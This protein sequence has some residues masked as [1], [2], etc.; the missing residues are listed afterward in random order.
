ML[1]FLSL[2]GNKA[3]REF[4]CVDIRENSSLVAGTQR[5]R[6]AALNR[7]PSPKW[8]C[9]LD[10]AEFGS[11]CQCLQALPKVEVFGLFVEVLPER[12]QKAEMWNDYSAGR[13]ELSRSSP[14]RCRQVLIRE[15]LAEKCRRW[16]DVLRL[17]CPRRA[18]KPLKHFHTG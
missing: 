18:A 1:R 15:G 6:Q 2:E 12:W 4:R 11:R 3:R 14:E 16:G 9:W 17:P 5:Q 13:V 8:R 7:A 10:D